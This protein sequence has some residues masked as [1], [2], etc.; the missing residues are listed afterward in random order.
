MRPAPP[1]CW[2]RRAVCGATELLLFLCVAACYMQCLSLGANLLWLGGCRG[3]Q[4]ASDFNHISLKQMQQQQQPH[5]RRD[6]RGSDGSA[7]VRERE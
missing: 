4:R 5:S 6:E 7:C 2:G 1:L 3:T